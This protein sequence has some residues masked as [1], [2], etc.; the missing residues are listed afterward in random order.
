VV[1]LDRTA[2]LIGTRRSQPH[3]LHAEKKPKKVLISLFI[4]TAVSLIMVLFTP[5]APMLV[6]HY[7]DYH[8]YVNE[9]V[10]SAS[11]WDYGIVA[12]GAWKFCMPWAASGE[13]LTKHELVT[14]FNPRFFVPWLIDIVI[15]FG[16]TFALAIWYKRHKLE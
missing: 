6:G 1:S 9:A 3:R 15:F 2:F 13:L 5:S 8:S 16:T 14:F 7:H 11:P 12:L 10:S 4:G